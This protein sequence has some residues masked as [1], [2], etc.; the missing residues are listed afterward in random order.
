MTPTETKNT[1]GDKEHHTEKP[2]TPEQTKN[3]D[4]DKGDHTDK[5]VTQEE[6]KHT[7]G[8]KGTEAVTHSHGQKVIQVNAVALQDISEVRNILTF[9]FQEKTFKT[10]Y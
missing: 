10:L 9:S 6:T 1:D 2:V 3:T 4:G 8:E 5:L 7:D